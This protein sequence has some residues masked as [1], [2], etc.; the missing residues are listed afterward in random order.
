M[1]DR[2]QVKTASVVAAVLLITLGPVVAVSGPALLAAISNPIPTSGTVFFETNSGVAVGLQGDYNVSSGNPFTDDQTLELV[3]NNG[4]VTVSGSGNA[5]VTLVQITGTETNVT[6]MDVSS[7]AVTIDPEDKPA[8]TV[9]GGADSVQFRDMAIDDGTTD[10]VYSGASGTTTLTVR[11]LAANTDVGAVDVGS[12]TLLDANT[13]DGSGT[14]TFTMTNSEHTV[15]LQTSDGGPNIIESTASP[16]GNLSSEPS[17]LSINV[18]D[19]DFPEDNVTVKFYLNGSLLDTKHVTSEGEV[20]ASIGNIDSATHTW[21]VTAEDEY[22]QT[23]ASSDFTF[24]T[25]GNLSFFRE[26]QPETLVNETQVNVTIFAGDQVFTRN[27]TDGT[28]DL[29]DLPTEDLVIR[30]EADGYFT[31]EVV[32]ESLTD[33]PRMYLLNESVSVANVTF[34]LEDKTGGNFPPET[35]QLFIKKPVTRNGTTAYETVAA[36]EFGTNGWTVTL[37]QDQRYRLIV[38]NTDDDTRVVG[39]YTATTDETVV[40]T[41]GSLIFKAG[42]TETYQWDANFT[43]SSGSSSIKFEFSDPDDATTDLNVKMYERGN[44]SNEIYNNTFD[45]PLGNASVTQLLSSSQSNKTWVVKFEGARNGE[46]IEGSRV[47]GKNVGPGVPLDAM[48]KQVFAVGLLIVF[49]GVLGAGMRSPEAAGI[50]VAL[51][52]GIFWHIQWLP[53]EVGGGA[54]VVGLLLSGLMMWSKTRG[55]A[56]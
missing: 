32:L 8:V 40:L 23:D 33:Q 42:D 7:S 4:N 1:I 16:T 12:N 48:W 18:T 46:A 25:P 53:P 3:T 19:P 37:E 26:T 38:K 28:V 51:L 10:F 54:L 30:A 6:N 14:V 2:D 36:D 5:N 43:T 13:T 39:P 47:L 50:V 20:T 27:T 34:Q 9:E 22:G 49:G 17:E 21:N 52:A 31:R 11:G 41:V 24:S 15:E 44:T 35:T 56:T 55:A 29:S 45:G